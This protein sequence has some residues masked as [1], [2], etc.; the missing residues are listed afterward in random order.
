[1]TSLCIVS[2]SITLYSTLIRAH[3]PDQNPPALFSLSL[4]SSSL[5]ATADRKPLLGDG[6]SRRYLCN[7]YIGAWAL[8]LRRL[9]GAITRF[10]PGNL[11]LALDLRR[12]AHRFTFILQ[13]QWATLF[14]AAVRQAHRP[15]QNRWA[16]I[17]LCSGPYVR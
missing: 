5:S 11:G 12:S 4:V 2:K 9:P 1:M 8:T 15:E 10:F 16:V 7:P 13:L 14:E 6:P 3:A 17:P